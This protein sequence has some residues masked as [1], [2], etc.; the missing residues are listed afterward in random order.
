[1]QNCVSTKGLVQPKTFIV[2]F[3]CVGEKMGE[4]GRRFLQL[5]PS[6]CNGLSGPVHFV[7]Y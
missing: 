4:D 6:F 2:G 7:G 1:M 5:C 3:V